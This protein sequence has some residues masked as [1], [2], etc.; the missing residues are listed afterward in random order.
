M[1]KIL[2]LLVV[3]KVQQCTA[4]RKPGP[5]LCLSAL[6]TGL[7]ASQRTVLPRVPRSRSLL[8]AQAIILALP[9]DLLGRILRRAWADRPPRAAAEE[10]RRA[11]DL[12]SV[13]RRWREL[14]RTQPLPLA[15]DF[16]TAPLCKAQRR[17]LLDPTQ[18]GRVEAASFHIEDALWEQP[19][20]EDLLARHGGRL[21]RLS[22]VPLRFV[23]TAGPDE[24]PALD[25]S[26]LRLTKL[27]I[28]C[29]DIDDLL[30]S[31]DWPEQVW[32][33]PE[34]LPGTLEELH[35]L[36]LEFHCLVFL[37]M[38]AAT[39]RRLGRAAAAAAHRPRDVC[40][41]GKG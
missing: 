41:R 30:Q 33:W 32:V 34:C 20:F 29:G 8:A 10:V 2:S 24:R 3:C 35:L 39:K 23:A 18:A 22:G 1:R 38:G 31:K 19:L 13:C 37:G 40:E 15:L 17:W 12:A 21:L 27:G 4:G 28:D 25:L 36:G 9:D 16:S 5:V 26:G 11:V 7:P 14:L 6:R